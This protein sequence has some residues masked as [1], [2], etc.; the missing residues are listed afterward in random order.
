[1]YLQNKLLAKKRWYELAM[2]SA[3]KDWQRDPVEFKCPACGSKKIT[4][5][6]ELRG[7]NPCWCP[8]CKHYFDQPTHFVCDCLE[9]GSQSKCHDC[10]NFHK[11]LASVKAIAEDLQSRSL[12]QNHSG[13]DS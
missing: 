3:L 4:P 11:L 13:F 6:P 1:M 2:Q 10:P 12:N 9:P 8:I 7:K 5:R